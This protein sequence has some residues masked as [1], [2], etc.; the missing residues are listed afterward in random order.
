M[1]LRT[2]HASP[3]AKI[4]DRALNGFILRK[5]RLQSEW[6]AAIPQRKFAE[7]I[8]VSHFLEGVEGLRKAFALPEKDLRGR[9]SCGRM[10]WESLLCAILADTG[11]FIW[12]KRWIPEE[13]ARHGDAALVSEGLRGLFPSPEESHGYLDDLRIR[14]GSFLETLRSRP[15]MAGIWRRF[16]EGVLL[17]AS[18]D[19]PGSGPERASGPSAS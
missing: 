2:A 4:I 11:E 16:G 9:A 17:P 1:M 5:G 10:A 13:L 7:M 14:Y 18:Q 8:C 15:S 19:R 12:S 3:Y 6:E